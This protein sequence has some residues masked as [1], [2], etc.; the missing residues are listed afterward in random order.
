MG[1]LQRAITLIQRR[2]LK[3]CSVKCLVLIHSACPY[4]NYVPKYSQPSMNYFCTFSTY[5]VCNLC[6]ANLH[7][8]VCTIK[9]LFL[10][11]PL[12]KPKISRAPSVC[13]FCS[14]QC[15]VMKVPVLPT[16]ALQCTTIGPAFWGL[17]FMTLR[18]NP[19]RG[20]GYSG[21][22]WSGQAVK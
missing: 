6:A 20:D 4:K 11:I 15:R 5:L 2:D 16:P 10:L 21:T 9:H 13:I 12:T 18:T 7:T 3:I 17:E 1:E 19:K 8:S 22:P 14:W